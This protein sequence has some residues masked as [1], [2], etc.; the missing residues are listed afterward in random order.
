[1][2]APSPRVWRNVPRLPSDMSVPGEGI[3]HR[4]TQEAVP[5]KRKTTNPKRRDVLSLFALRNR[6]WAIVRAKVVDE[7]TNR[8]QVA[9]AYSTPEEDSSALE[10]PR[11]SH[12]IDDA[13]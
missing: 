9:M 11:T 7:P 6:S 3:I 13:I 5:H 1:M 4:G 10:N 8:L 2:R 12:S